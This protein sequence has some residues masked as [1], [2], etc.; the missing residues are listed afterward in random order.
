MEA[1][2]EDARVVEVLVDVDLGE[3]LALRVPEAREDELVVGRDVEED[4]LLAVDFVPH[5]QPLAVARLR[6]AGLPRRTAPW[7]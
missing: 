2:L 4:V 5:E 6:E 7:P 1:Q 3:H